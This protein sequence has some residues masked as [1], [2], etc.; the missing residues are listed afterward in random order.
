MGAR[1]PQ[2]E[3][4]LD[5]VVGRPGERL[6]ATVTVQGGGAAVRVEGLAM[7]LVTRVEGLEEGGT[8][9]AWRQPGVVSAFSLPTF[10]LSP[11]ETVVREV[12]CVLPWEMPLTHV[13]GRRLRGARAALR[14][15]M[16]IDAAIDR[17]DFDEIAVHALPAQDAFLQALT[18]LGF[19]LGD[20]EVKH[21][22]LRGGTAQTLPYRQEIEAHFPASYNRR[23][24][25]RLEIVFLARADSL[26][27]T[28]GIYG[29]YTFDHADLDVEAA[30]AWL[31]AHLHANWRR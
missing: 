29:P 11:G 15:T 12:D 26:D 1:A 19:R 22:R 9:L 16:K 30:T 21:G 31:V 17:G 24:D 20:A 23:H 14:T 25:D 10:T 7:E 2:V 8:E 13:G 4:V 6:T 27:L 18:D 3:T 5:R 28:T